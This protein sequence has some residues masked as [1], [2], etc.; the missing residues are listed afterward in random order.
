LI[1]NFFG[2]Y[3]SGSLISDA[4]A[5][6]FYDSLISFGAPVFRVSRTAL[7]YGSPLGCAR[8]SVDLGV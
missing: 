3:S 5:S 7:S 2:L 8:V 1:K 4:L 6:Y